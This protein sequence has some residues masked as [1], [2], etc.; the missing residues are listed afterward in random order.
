M[1]TQT[2]KHTTHDGQSSWTSRYAWD[3]DADTSAILVGTKPHRHRARYTWT[4]SLVRWPEGSEEPT[5]E[6]FSPY[7]R[8]QAQALAWLRGAVEGLS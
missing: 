4:A 6:T 1:N 5:L 2:A 3:V 8:T 7:F